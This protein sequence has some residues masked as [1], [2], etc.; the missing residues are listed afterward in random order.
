MKAVRTSKLSVSLQTNQF[1]LLMLMALPFMLLI[2]GCKDDDKSGSGLT[3]HEIKLPKGFPKMPIPES[4]RP[5]AERIALGRK[6]YYDPILSN[7]GLS[8]SSCHFQRL[9]FTVNGQ[10]G[11]PVLHHANLGWKD[12]F[13]W[14]GRKQG[15]LEDVMLFEVEE[16]FG[17][18]ISKLNKH[19][20]Y[21]DLFAKAY[22]VEN[23]TSKDVA[24]ALAQFFRVLISADSKYDEVQ[25]S[26]AAFTADEAKGFDIFNSEKGSCFHCHTPPFFADNQLHNIGL[27]SVFDNP[28]NQG[29]FTVNGDSSMLG[30]MRTANL[31]NL[32]LRNR[33]MHDGRFSTIE[34]VI[35]FYNG[36]VRRSAS[37]DPVMV[38]GSGSTKL[39]LTPT[40]KSQLAAFLRTLTDSTFISN[41][42]FSNPH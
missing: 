27:D 28:A 13:M 25:R 12:K 14:D 15:S 5:F 38:K 9:G 4:N 16:F 41:P 30:A 23:I 10:Q 20:N 7:N 34:E 36:D 6:L 18:D 26:E 31:R 24:K 3:P 1:S 2:S 17:T 22:G 19:P 21:P 33:F 40:E 8:C 39:D 32:S 11:M 35:D 37:L 29:Y 42:A